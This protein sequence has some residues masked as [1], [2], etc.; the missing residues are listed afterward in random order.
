MTL[1]LQYSLEKLDQLEGSPI[2]LPFFNSDIAWQIGTL[3]RELAQDLPKPIMIDVTLAN[4][5]VLFHSPSKQG[6]MPDNDAWV[7]RKKKTVLRFGKSSF[8]MGRKL[9]KKE[10]DAGCSLGTEKAY[11]VSSLEYATHGGSVPIKAA[12]FDGLYGA[13]TISGLAQEE[14]HMFALK[15]L[16]ETKRRL[17]SVEK[18]LD[19]DWE[20]GL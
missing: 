13:L 12:N 7:N 3:A 1:P 14:D 4:G 5:Q 8:Y 17:E 11:F 16:V 2:V 18:Q 20:I 10:K 6:T 9:A 15:V 19:L